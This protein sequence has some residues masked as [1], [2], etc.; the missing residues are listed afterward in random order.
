[1]I[2][3]FHLSSRL[4]FVWFFTAA[5]IAFVLWLT[6]PWID[7]IGR[8]ITTP[9]ALALIVGLGIVPGVLNVRLLSA[10][11]FDD[12]LGN[13]AGSR[14]PAGVNVS[15][16]SVLVFDDESEHPAGRSHT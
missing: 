5:W 13:A 1:M 16:L 10:L 11:L 7:D 14:R 3:R 2:S 6:I 8:S 12:E 15:L 4:L 9:V